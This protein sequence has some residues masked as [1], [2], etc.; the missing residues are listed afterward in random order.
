MYLIGEKKCPYC[1]ADFLKEPKRGSRCKKCGDVFHVITRPSDKKIIITTEEEF[2]V[3]NFRKKLEYFYLDNPREFEK[4]LET[5]R[6][7][8]K[9]SSRFGHNPK[10]RDVLW[11]LANDIVAQKTK[12]GDFSNLSQVYFVMALFLHEIGEP[13]FQLLRASHRIGLEYFKGQNIKNVSIMSL[14]CCP[15]CQ[16]LDGK[17][18]EVNK[19]LKEMPLPSK[20]CTH[21][22][23][24]K[25]PDGWCVCSYT[26]VD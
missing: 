26:I 22:I 14:S 1:N 4:A 7:N 16:K 23:N 18:M 24:A 3:F 12:S 25:A 5:A 21:K 15:A 10:E 2:Q 8:L 19:A 6:K 17:K 13:H 9:K 20:N 11:R